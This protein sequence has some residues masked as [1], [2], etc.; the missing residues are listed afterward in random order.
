MDDSKMSR[1]RK[2][3]LFVAEAVT[4]AQVARLAVLARALPDDRFEVHFASAKFDELVFAGTQFVRWHIHSISPERAFHAVSMGLRF[5]DRQTL[6]RYVEDD[7]RLIAQVKPDLVVGDLR[8]SL[9]VSGP[10]S[11]VKVASLCNAYWSP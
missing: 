10:V 8:W 11:G 4:L 1:I 7:L 9:A 2:K 3:V 6:A 5:Y